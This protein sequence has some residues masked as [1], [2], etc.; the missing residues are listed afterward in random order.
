MINSLPAP[1]SDDPER[2]WHYELI[3]HFVKK[4]SLEQE[5]SAALLFPRGEFNKLKNGHPDFDMMMLNG[6]RAGI[7]GPQLVEWMKKGDPVQLVWENG[8]LVVG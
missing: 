8:H 3:Y 1:P 5:I 4:R 7:L 2:E 6:W